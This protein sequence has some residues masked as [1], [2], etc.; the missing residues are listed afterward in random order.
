MPN[1]RTRVKVCGMTQPHQVAAA[2]DMGVDAIG[3]ILH[4]DSPRC[5]SLET[6]QAIRAVV[7]ALVTLVGVFVDA[8]RESIQHYQQEIG[9][10]LLQL[11]GTESNQFGQSL[12]VPFIKAIRAR[13]KSTVEHELQQYPAA[14]AL[15]LDA[16][17]PDRHGG[18]GKRID[19]ALWPRR[20]TQKM[21]LAGGLNADNIRAAVDTTRPYAVDVNS[22][23]E[24]A[25][26]V[27][28]L[29]LLQRLMHELAGAG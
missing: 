23:I 11:H 28:N 20:T 2:V 6:A 19:P 29:E 12:D 24:S 17:D 18:T 7:P 8:D 1:V 15:L 25:P 27:K 3:M 10:D 9:L 14:R 21:I 13:D 26:G 5:I 22:G 4:A 16:W